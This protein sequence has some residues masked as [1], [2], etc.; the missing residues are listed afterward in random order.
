M[1]FCR[2]IFGIFS[3]TQQEKDVV[4]WDKS[5]LPLKSSYLSI[6]SF[7]SVASRVFF[8]CQIPFLAS[9]GVKQTKFGLWP[10]KYA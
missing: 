10:Y 5:M 1:F 4:M 9:L 3:L 6:P 7:N 8:V 2:T